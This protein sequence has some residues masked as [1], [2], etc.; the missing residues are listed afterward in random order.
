MLVIGAILLAICYQPI[1]IPRLDGDRTFVQKLAALDWI[2]CGIFAV[3]VCV[4]F[5][6][7]CRCR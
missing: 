7:D 4:P 5:A 3:A 2:G 1:P 6:S